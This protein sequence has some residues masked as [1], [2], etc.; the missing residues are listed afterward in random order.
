MPPIGTDKGS[1]MPSRLASWR[2]GP[3]IAAIVQRAEY[4][5]AQP[6]TRVHRRVREESAGIGTSEGEVMLGS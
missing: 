1:G 5:A 4:S 6:T 2:L 3:R